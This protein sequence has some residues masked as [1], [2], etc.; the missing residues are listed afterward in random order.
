MSPEADR[1]KPR[2]TIIRQSSPEQRKHTMRS[3][4]AA[5]IAAL[6]MLALVALIVRNLPVIKEWLLQ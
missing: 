1:P 5:A 4:A 6:L 3:M 2:R